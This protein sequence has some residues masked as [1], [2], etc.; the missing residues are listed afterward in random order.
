[1]SASPFLPWKLLH[2]YHLYQF[3]YRFR[4]Y[5]LIYDVRFSFSDFILVL[6]AACLKI[7]MI[8]LQKGH[9]V[10]TNRSIGAAFLN[11][12]HEV[13]VLMKPVFSEDNRSKDRIG[14]LQRH[15]ISQS[16]LCVTFAKYCLRSSIPVRDTHL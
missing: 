10:N 3:F 9:E 16:W 8:R 4:M 12:L 13:L 15:S 5:T 1:M 2:L 11:K 6:P 7:P 14:S